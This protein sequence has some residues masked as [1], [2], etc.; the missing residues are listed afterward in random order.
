M[1]QS[2]DDWRVVSMCRIC[3]PGSVAHQNLI[4]ITYELL[5]RNLICSRQNA[6][7][8]YFTWEYE[9]KNVS[10]VLLKKN[11]KNLKN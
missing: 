5:G 8:K 2:L 7:S 6:P 9:I 3:A 10:I 11:K 4:L 1:F